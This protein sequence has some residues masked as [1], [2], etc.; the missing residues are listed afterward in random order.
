VSVVERRRS[1]WHDARFA[2]LCAAIGALGSFGVL[3][4]AAR[5]ADES[6][7]M[8]VP[9]DSANA[10]PKV[11]IPFDF[12]SKFDDGRYG[13]IVG[14]LIWK[15]LDKDG[16]AEKKSNRK[17]SFL[18]PDSMED[19]RGLCATNNLHFAPDAPLEKVKE[20]VC[21]DFDAQ[22]GIWGS[23]ER[24]PGT[25]GEIYDFSIKCVDFSVDPPKVIYEKTNVRTNS[26]SEIPH[27]YVKE[28]LDKLYGRT[29]G[30]AAKPDPAAEERWKNGPNLIVGGD[31]ET[32]VG[33]VPKGWDSRA[34]QLREP[35]GNLVK[36]VAEHGSGGNRIIRFQFPQ[37]VGDNE[38]V[39]Y[40]SQYFPVHEGA[41]YRFQCRWRTTG[42]TV[43]VFIKGYD[44]AD[45][46][47]RSESGPVGADA[48]EGD[49]SSRNRPSGKEMRECYRAQLQLK[50]PSG[51]WNTH[52]QDFTPAQ[53]KYTPRWGRVMLYAYIGAGTVDFDDVV[54]KEIIPAASQNLVKDKR[55]SSASKITLKEME[56]NERRGRKTREQLREERKAAP[57]KKTPPKRQPGDE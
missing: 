42:P 56:E 44:E 6:G 43:K 3:A 1:L 36:C 57:K 30:E 45:T 49:S 2:V 53:T 16:L 13:Q 28:M 52:T 50:G 41:K 18:I 40:Y 37:V 15:R 26:V 5:A 39:M 55:L 24:A 23:V 38:G 47:Y 19:V 12:V 21:K 29:P 46:V 51:A 33:G 14:D 22:I 35:L 17:T 31:F 54:I 32:V 25:D 10:R 20:A 8:A 4:A 11:V 34:G 7:V 48:A 27:L 9:K